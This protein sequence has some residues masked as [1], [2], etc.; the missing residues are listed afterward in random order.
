MTPK[1]PPRGARWPLA[2]PATRQIPS[3]AGFR[4]PQRELKTR[5]NR[6]LTSPGALRDPPGGTQKCLKSQ[7]IDFS[8]VPP[9]HHT[10]PQKGKNRP[11]NRLFDPQPATKRCQ[12][13]PGSPCHKANI[14]MGGFSEAPKGAQNT[15]KPRFGVPWG[16]P[17]LPW[18]HPKGKNLKNRLFESAPRTP[19]CIP[20]R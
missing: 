5:A 19:N 10:G 2:A 8:K 6:V 14:F 20:K 1:R 13:A 12:V 11:G 15:R 18:R 7:K 16:P 4:R 9:E 17:G 3:W